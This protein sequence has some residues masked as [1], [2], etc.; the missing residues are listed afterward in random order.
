[1][2]TKLTVKKVGEVVDR[3]IERLCA[4]ETSHLNLT[5]ISKSLNAFVKANTDALRYAK[6]RGEK[7]NIPFYEEL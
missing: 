3:E 2:S 6:D 7:P 1:M 4:G 5:A